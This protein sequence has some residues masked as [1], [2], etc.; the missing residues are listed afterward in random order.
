MQ[1]SL[2]EERFHENFETRGELGASVSVWKDGEEVL[3]RAGGFRDREKTQAWTRETPVL[4]WSA[5]KGPSAA[6][7]L[8]ACQER[9][10]SIHGKVAEVWPEFAA[11]GKESL[12]IAEVLSHQAGVPAL[13]REVPVLDHAAAVHALEEE[14]PRWRAGE[15]HGYHPRTFGV[16]LDELVRRIAGVPLGA[17]WRTHFAE[18]LDLSFW[19][20]IDPALAETVAPVFAARSAPAKDD[21]FYQA[22]LASGS[23]TAQAFASPRGLHSVSSLNTPEA[24]LA[25]F[26]AFGGIG[27]AA[28]LGK[29]YALLAAGGI[30]NA[31]RS[32]EPQTLGWAETTLVQGQDLVLQIPTAFSAGFMKDPTDASGEK[33][34]SLFGPSLRA[35]GQPGAGGSLAFADPENRLSFAYVM[36]QMEPGVL[37]NAKA[38]LLVEA[39]YS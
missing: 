26:P 4:V 22:V 39:L 36:N 5:T 13:A 34:R 10:I 11:H 24:R 19:I 15:A 12:T 30:W 37:P 17:Y 31:Q 1:L 32:F 18:P 38:L 20:G 25:S 29:F 6:C 35:F 27:T 33:L 7:V 9:G 8:H 23:L 21:P 3:S 28:A 16:L 14:A 2:L